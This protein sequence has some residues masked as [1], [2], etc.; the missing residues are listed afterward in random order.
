MDF[1]FTS[2][3]QQFGDA[4]RRYLSNEYG[5]ENRHGIIASAAGISDLH[6]AN[7]AELGLLALPVPEAQGGFAGGPFDLLVVMQELGRTLVVEPYW[8]TAVGVE[9]LRL[10]GNERY[11]QVLTAVAGGECRLAFTFHEPG[12]GYDLTNIATRATAKGSGYVL[13]GHK[14]LV[15]H[16]AQADY[17]LVPALLDERL[18]LFMVDRAASGAQAFDHRTVDGQRIATLRFDQA[19]GQ[20]L[21]I[22]Q[23]PALVEQ[24][25]DYGIFLLCAEAIGALDALNTATVEYAKTR[26]QFGTPIGRFQALQH[27]MV[28]MRIHAE[29]ARS[30]TFLA[31]ARYASGDPEVRKAAISAAKVRVGQAA[32]FVGQQAVQLHGAMGVAEEFAAGHWFKRLAVIDSA[33]GNVDHHLS[34]FASLP[35]FCTL[36]A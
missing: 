32:R 14:A 21:S 31:A 29:Q 26:Q 12:A 23:I 27:R 16:G 36:P 33:L 35:G 2:E 6:W 17:W 18:G 5:F 30:I 15:T 24:V 13:S 1:Q 8:A 22:E 3:Q 4:L 28:D 25:A 19:E 11:A 20:L 10:A 7:L 34:R 9:A